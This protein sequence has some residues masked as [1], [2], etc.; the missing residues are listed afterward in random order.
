MIVNYLRDFDHARYIR[1]LIELLKSQNIYFHIKHLLISMFSV[2]DSPTEQE[3]QLFKKYIS[4]SLNLKTVFFEHAY[5][6]GWTETVFKNGIM[7]FLIDQPAQKKPSLMWKLYLK[8]LPTDRRSGNNAGEYLRH[9]STQ[10]LRNQLSEPNETVL[11][12]VNKIRDQSLL[13]WLSFTLNDWSNPKV[14]E[15]FTKCENFRDTDPFGYFNALE[16]MLSDIPNF[17]FEQIRELLFTED[18]FDGERNSDHHSEKNLIKDLT[19]KIPFVVIGQLLH[20]LDAQIN[21]PRYKDLGFNGDFKYK[22]VYL[23]D[24][25][26]IDN[27]G[28]LY[29]LL[30]SCLRKAAAENN[31]IFKKFIA[32]Y[33]DNIN[34]SYLR[35]LIFAYDI[36]VELY[37]AEVS[38]LLH[39]LNR[40]EMLHH[41]GR[42]NVEFR[43]LFEKAF[44][45]FSAPNKQQALELIKHL[46]VKDEIHVYQRAD[47][48]RHYL[49][50]GLTKYFFMKRLP[51]EVLEKQKEL[52]TE[53]Q[54]LARKFK[55]KVDQLSSQSNIA[56]AVGRP[57]SQQAYTKMRPSHWISSFKKYDSDDRNWDESF[58]KGGLHEHSW[59]FKEYLSKNPT[60]ENIDLVA[61]LV[62]DDDIN[63]TYKVRAIYGLTEANVDAG[64]LLPLI[65]RGIEKNQFRTDQSLFLSSI[66]YLFNCDCYNDN[67]VNFAIDE[68]LN[69][70]TPKHWAEKERQDK[71]SV[72]GLVTAAIN[73]SKGKA[74]EYLVYINE[75]KY[76]DKVFEIIDILLQKESP[77]VRAVIYY[78][79]AFLMRVDSERA[80][81]LFVKH[82]IREESN[83]VLASAIWSLQYL[84]NYDFDRLQPI[85]DKLIHVKNLG[86]DDRRGVSTILFISY[87]KGKAS[88]KKLFTDFLMFSEETHFWAIH[89]AFEHFYL[90][91]D[92]PQKC[93]EILFFLLKISKP[94][95]A[96]KDLNFQLYKLENIKFAD[97]KGL[98]EA[99]I[100]S[101]AFR[102]TEDLTKYLTISCKDEPFD[103][104]NLFSK[105][106]SKKKDPTKNDHLRDND[107]ATQFIIAGFSA[108][109][110]NDSKSIK[111]RTKLL[112]S[113]DNVLSDYRFRNRAERILDAV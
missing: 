26:D 28:L 93:L 15:L 11:D 2:I 36:N 68:A 69:G 41:E 79:Y 1:E 55:D 96:S 97:V 74:A 29:K 75:K 19:D 6:K 23:K 58:L 39:H 53:Y 22:D 111:Y 57:L 51:K 76:E 17:A 99:Y 88:A 25:T 38:G 16:N 10:Y 21:N 18:Y 80:F 91:D 50:I 102:L 94:T 85:F 98:L 30:A 78:R 71:T 82:L 12:F 105:A 7:D 83:E 47:K 9:V 33:K 52:K 40:N 70:E 87:L 59:A 66:G 89:E 81:T 77:Q 90:F 109:K 104:V 5:G 14:L 4:N 101:N 92:S 63:P 106:I 42:L 113:F 110:G 100:N 37:T 107:H 67:L 61:T 45:Y 64:S 13:R 56:Q 95:E 65:E 73:S 46:T 60:K 35:L 20:N 3:I 49:T 103:C 112:M 72:N 32:D 62:E 54:E 44:P 8:Y 48:K 108:I 34:H 27:P 43:I 24:D 31:D 84:A 86:D